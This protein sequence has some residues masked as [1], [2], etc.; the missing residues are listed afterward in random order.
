MLDYRDPKSV[1]LSREESLCVPPK[2]MS[3]QLPVQAI[4]DMIDCV[5]TQMNLYDHPKLQVV[6]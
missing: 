1:T 6:L 5:L 2:G 4:S 3:C